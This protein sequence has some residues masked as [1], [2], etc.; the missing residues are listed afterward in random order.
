[1]KPL[2]GFAEALR[3]DASTTERFG[4]SGDL[5]MEAA[6]IGM[7]AA[8]ESDGTLRRRSEEHTS[9]LQ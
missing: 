3:L 8:L 1:M 9:E 2:V 5:L 7:A 6:A 4:L